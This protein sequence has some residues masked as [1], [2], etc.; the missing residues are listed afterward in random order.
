VA[1][2]Q[3]G[4]DGTP[5]SAD[6]ALTARALAWL[7]Q[8]DHSRQELRNKLMRHITA[9][10]PARAES[11]SAGASG[12][13]GRPSPA[14]DADTDRRAA[15]K[16]VEI[17]LDWLEAHHHLSQQRFLES[18]LHS[19]S[20][21]YGNARIRHELAQQGIAIPAEVETALRASEFDRARA[22]WERKFGGRSNP[23]SVPS[24]EAARQ[25]RFLAGRGFS[26]DV[27][28]RVLREMNAPAAPSADLDAAP[29]ESG[30]NTADPGNVEARLEASQRGGAARL[31][32]I[33]GP[34]EPSN[35][36]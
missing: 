29:P 13:N 27:I 6:R 22:V 14:E 10:M 21:R 9:P 17:V 36:D 1:E 35:L 4:T 5:P 19:R 32:L 31:R 33:G 26:G 18:R 16:Q 28:R 34:E 30:L 11:S 15:V 25:V 3:G 7:A 12:A 2:S 20:A 23:T 24:A 8:R